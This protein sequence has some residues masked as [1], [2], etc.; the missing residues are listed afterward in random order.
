ML[1]ALTPKPN[2][3]NWSGVARQSLITRAASAI[4]QARS[5]STRPGSWSSSR[6]EDDPGQFGAIGQVPQ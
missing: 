2:S 1:S 3:F 6:C 4:T 5:A